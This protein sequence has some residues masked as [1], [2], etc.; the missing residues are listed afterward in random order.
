MAG[1]AKACADAARASAVTAMSA[2]VAYGPAPGVISAL[3]SVAIG[4]A[5]AVAVLSDDDRP[6]SK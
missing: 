5:A 1:R 6:A 2:A 4:I 3:P